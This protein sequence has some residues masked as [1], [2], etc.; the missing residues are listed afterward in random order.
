FITP[1]GKKADNEKTRLAVYELAAQRV[2]G[3]IELGWSSD[4]TE[5]GHQDE[6]EARDL[7]S[8]NFARVQEVGFVVNTTR[9]FDVGC[10]PAGLVGSDGMIEVKSRVQKHQ[11]RTIMESTAETPVPTEHTIQVQTSLFVTGRQWCDYTTYCAG[12][13]MV[14]IRTHRDDEV[15]AKIIE[16]ATAAEAQIQAIVAEY[17]AKIANMRHIN[18]VRIERDF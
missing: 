17:R 16:S 12:M 1:T 9:R 11:L 15:I 3:F 5:R 14:P 18:T 6:I 8:K 2:S 4:D 10:S 13:P 7:Y